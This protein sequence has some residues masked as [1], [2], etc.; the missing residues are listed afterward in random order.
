M[1]LKKAITGIAAVGAIA[2]A[3]MVGATGTANAS[4][5]PRVR[6][7]AQAQPAATRSFIYGYYSTAGVCA[8]I[9]GLVL[10]SSSNYVGT[11]CQGGNGA[12]NPWALYIYY[13][14]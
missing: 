5:S 13:E 6:V 8:E 12:P 4:A 7:T 1:H 2:T 10:A 14:Q 11:F 9:G 3:G